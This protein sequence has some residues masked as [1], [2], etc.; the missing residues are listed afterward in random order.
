MTQKKKLIVLLSILLVISLLGWYVNHLF[1]NDGKSMTEL[2]NFSVADT[3][4]VDRLIISDAAGLKFEI[5]R[6]NQGWVDANDGCIVQEHV[7]LILE[8]I[9]NIEFKGYVP[10]NSRKQFMKLMSAQST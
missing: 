3:S 8:T 6:T 5:K 4:K 2:I 9:K 10:E 1:K 7:K